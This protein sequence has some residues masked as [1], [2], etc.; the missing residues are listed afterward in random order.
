[1]GNKK[2]WLGM[3]VMILV[4][5]ISVIGCGG[6]TNDSGIDETVLTLHGAPAGFSFFVFVYPGGIMPTTQSEASAM[7]TSAI[8]AASGGSPFTLRFI[9]GAPN[10]T[11]LVQISAGMERRLGLV[12][13]SGTSGVSISWDSM[14]NRDSLP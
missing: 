11:R 14:T 10:G 5:G 13:F 6:G 2:F 9:G 4:F 1:M 7:T 3:L 8:A 12:N